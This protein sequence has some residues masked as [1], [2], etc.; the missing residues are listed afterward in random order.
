MMDEADLRSRVA[1]RKVRC[2][3]QDLLHRASTGLVRSADTIV[4]ED[5]NVAGMVRNR[6][7]A[8]VISDCDWR[9]TPGDTSGAAGRETGTPAGDGRNPRPSGRGVVKMI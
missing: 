4:I 8:R 2:P 9:K 3:R 5:L 6:R 7:L 1:H